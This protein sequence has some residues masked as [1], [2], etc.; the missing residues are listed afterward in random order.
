MIKPQNVK[1]AKFPSFKVLY[2]TKKFSIAW[3]TYDN[4]GPERLAMRWNGH[5]DSKSQGYP[6]RGAYPVWFMLP[7]EMSLSVL[8][9]LDSVRNNGSNRK[10]IKRLLKEVIVRKR[11]EQASAS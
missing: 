10:E 2:E 11:Y 7:S 5:H 8:K 3:G 4:E 9:G 1:P 6:V